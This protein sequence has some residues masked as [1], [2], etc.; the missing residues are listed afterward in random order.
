MDDIRIRNAA[1][2]DWDGIAALEAATYP[3]DRLS[4]GRQALASSPTTCL[5]AE[6]DGQLAGYLLAL[7]YPLLQCPDPSR[8]E[9]SDL[10][11]RNLHIQ[12]L[13]IAPEF[14]GRWLAPRLL[15]H[16]TQTAMSQQFEHISTVAVGSTPTLLKRGGFSTYPDVVLPNSYGG[17][18]TYMSLA[19]PPT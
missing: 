3:E 7:P 19:L 13:V 11:T 1:D 12:D 17:H 4:G 9:P 10:R 16:L 2:S 5:V 8:A 18:G 15:K 6:C 14:G